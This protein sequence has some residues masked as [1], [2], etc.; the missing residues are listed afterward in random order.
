MELEFLVGVNQFTKILESPCSEKLRLHATFLFFH[1]DAEDPESC[2]EKVT[3]YDTR[4][5]QP[6]RSCGRRGERVAI[7]SV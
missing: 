2:T 1:P 7:W 5:N 4:V 6:N 3:Y